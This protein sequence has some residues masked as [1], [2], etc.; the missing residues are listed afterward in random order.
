M[1]N[2]NATTNIQF[3][4]S[5]RILQ[6]PW[7]HE[8]GW[9]SQEKLRSCLLHYTRFA[10]KFPESNTISISM[11]LF[12]LVEALFRAY[13]VSNRKTLNSNEKIDIIKIAD[14]EEEIILSMLGSAV[15]LT[16]KS[17]LDEEQIELFIDVLKSSLEEGSKKNEL[18]QAC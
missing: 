12:T 8:S 5:N 14:T 10:Q 2:K 18:D 15:V 13:E 6:F 16:G 17:K 11:K 9:G 1:N 4:S 3:H 7:T